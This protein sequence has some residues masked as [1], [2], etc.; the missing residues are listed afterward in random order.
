MK[1]QNNNEQ[2]SI[3]I[4]AMTMVALMAALFGMVALSTRQTMSMAS[5]ANNQLELIYAAESAIEQNYAQLG[6]VLIT[7]SQGFNPSVATLTS[8][9][10]TSTAP[11]NYPQVTFNVNT[12]VPLGIS[13]I[14][15][16]TAT[17]MTGSVG[18]Q[19][20]RYMLITHASR[21]IAGTDMKVKLQREIRYTIDPL[22]RFAIFYNNDMELH[23]GPTF[24]ITGRVH[25]N[26]KFYNGGANGAQNYWGSVAS[27]GGTSASFM[28]N[29]A[30][31]RSTISGGVTNST[32]G[33]VSNI[34]YG[35]SQPYTTATEVPPGSDFQA[36]STNLN[37]NDDGPI[38]LIQMPRD[39][40]SNP[41][42]MGTNRL[43]NQAALKVVVSSNNIPTIYVGG[44]NNVV[45]T[46]GSLYTYMTQTM[47]TAG[48][49]MSDFRQGST[50]SNVTTVDVNISGMINSSNSFVLGTSIPATN[51]WPTNTT[52]PASLRGTAIPAALQGASLWNGI[53]WAGY[54]DGKTQKRGVRLI[55]GQKIPTG[56][57]TMVTENS[58][59]VIGDYNTGGSG[60]SVPSNV[61]S[62]SYVTNKSTATGYTNQPSSVMADA[63][64]LL[65][66]RWISNGYNNV[67]AAGSR[68]AVNTTYNTAIITGNVRSTNGTYSGG[69]EN[70]PRFLEDW[71]GGLRSTYYGSLV[72]LFASEQATNIW[73]SGVY[74][75][76]N[77]NWY[78]DTA[79]EQGSL[80]PGTPMVRSVKKS[81]WAQIF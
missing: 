27:V 78:F 40:F 23:N 70:L 65:S 24:N 77:R 58:L 20:Y 51:Y 57:M 9:I 41:D 5:R 16:N 80:P 59:Y 29:N 75:P 50:V 11:T 62:G 66:S 8:N 64:N 48:G 37:L 2:G 72:N 33:G 18:A 71:S 49:K 12:I 52:V 63:V 17:N 22:Y 1:Y 67:T 10:N 14:P 26:G 45:L 47:F 4:V 55:N 36:N 21:N 61:G 6:R 7:N 73:T 79:F 42:P 28:P 39:T 19:E 60:S 43:Y 74:S 34:T 68:D 30:D 54:D 44:T 35:A 15:Q 76:P 3:L 25:S 69:I 13:G 32:P 56:G 53:V 38:E 31:G 81:A 46:N